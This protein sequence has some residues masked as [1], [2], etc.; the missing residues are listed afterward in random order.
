MASTTQR[1]GEPGDHLLPSPAER[2]GPG[3]Q[4][5]ELQRVE[6]PISEL[7]CAG[8]AAPLAA[9]I[10]RVPGV[11]EVV[12][13][14]VTERTVVLF[15]P[16][17]TGVEE[18][19]RAVEAEGV[20]VG[21]SMARWRLRV[22]GLRCASR[23]RRL[24]QAVEAVPGVHAAI[25]N[26][27]AD[28][29]TVEY[30]PRRTD[31]AAVRDVV[32]S[33][34]FD[35]GPAPSAQQFIANDAP[36]TENRGAIR[37][38][39]RRF[40]F[41][42]AIAVPTVLLSHPDLFGLG[43]VMPPG[44]AARRAVW[45]AL[46]LL[47]LPVMLCSGA[48][49][50]HGLWTAL[51]HRSADMNTLIAL[52]ITVAW[53]SSTA[54]VFAPSLFVRGDLTPV[55]YDVVV[56]V[57]A[58]VALGQALET[59]AK[60]P[61][62]DALTRLTDLQPTTA[63]VMRD[64]HERVIP[65]QEVVVGDIV[66]TNPGERFPVDGEVLEGVSVVDESMVTGDSPA[67]AKGPRDPLV[68][69]SVNRTARLAYRATKV[70]KDT[71]PSQII[72]T[73]RDAQGSKAPIQRLVDAVASYFTPTAIILAILAFMLWYTFGPDP[74][75][76]YAVSAFVTVVIV[77]CPGA[78]ALATP[79]SLV[80]GI[81]TGAK[82]GILM[83]TG[84]A[85]EA[86]DELEVII[87]RAASIVTQ[88]GPS[89]TDVVRPDAAAAIAALRRLGL[90]VALLSDDEDAA[91]AIARQVGVDQVL[92]AAHP[93][94]TPEEVRRLQAGGKRVAMV[95]DGI[96]DASALAQADVGIA[97]GAAYDVAIEGADVTL[98]GR[99]LRQAVAAMELS[100]ATMRNIK[101]NLTGVFLYNAVGLPVAAGALYPAFG[102]LL[103][104]LIAAAA[105]AFSSV[106]VVTNANRLRRFAPSE[107]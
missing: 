83:R 1:T 80:V 48:Q 93:G 100:R 104:P 27:A 64:G 78:L 87:V 30:S 38:L 75:V 2:V 34:G 19:V 99:R 61:S 76:L 69:G 105:M 28:S 82:H 39:M 55:F 25:V 33:A 40:W 92:A 14:P 31:V 51:K 49:F 12:V 101:Q 70:G 44:S 62:A 68:G 98:L 97:I 43:D 10:E 57:V 58:L 94:V 47:T 71:L 4:R 37:L 59:R 74:A 6:L 54:A 52:G 24:E 5:L 36:D 26:P 3:A 106:L 8:A 85:V 73:V 65:V 17:V 67:A 23:V 60:G 79:A 95:G 41:T 89:L 42:A 102:I 22:G 13:N 96:R 84:H 15:D 90:E 21:R 91:R 56:V 81:G 86:A 77:A 53:L 45:L 11:R 63:R 9:R 29:L 16:G 20:E 35:I 32:V 103:S 107:A 72:R 18:L 88:D 46:G 66:V 50:Y 7:P